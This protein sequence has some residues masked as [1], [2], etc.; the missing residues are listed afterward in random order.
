MVELKTKMLDENIIM[1]YA[2]DE[3]GN[4]YFIR[5]NETGIEYECAC[6]VIPCRYTYSI[7]DKI[8]EEV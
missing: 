3:D 1:H 2:E 4:K 5:Q 8:I 7:T 6:D